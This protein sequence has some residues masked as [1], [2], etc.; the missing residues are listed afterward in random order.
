MESYKIKAKK[1][2]KNSKHGYYKCPKNIDILFNG[3]TF[4]KE[5]ERLLYTAILHF[6][7]NEY[8]NTIPIN[9]WS[10]G[11]FQ[12]YRSECNIINYN[13]NNFY[14][15]DINKTIYLLDK[16]DDIILIERRNKINKI[17]KKDVIIEEKTFLRKIKDFF[18]K[19]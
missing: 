11:D 5:G 13:I 4:T 12:I 1:I 3:Y 19:K 18:Q 6:I 7:S 14:Y 15:D 17:L 9:V 16:K 10:N 8:K 2:T